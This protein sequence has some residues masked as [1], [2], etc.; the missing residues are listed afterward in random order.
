MPE[1][2]KRLARVLS[3]RLGPGERDILTLTVTFTYGGEQQGLDR[4]ILDDPQFEHGRFRRRWA[5]PES[6]ELV[7][8]ICHA[9]GVGNWEAVPGR[10][11]F[12]LR[13]GE[14]IVGLAPL[15]TEPGKAFYLRDLFPARQEESSKE[16][17]G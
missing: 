3:T 1:E 4:F 11:L 13:E 5:A 9:C 14:E 2:E 17:N 8:A 7:R 6:M 12:V 16:A 10:T 15:P